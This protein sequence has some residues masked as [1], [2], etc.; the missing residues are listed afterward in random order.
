LRRSLARSS[1]KDS[2]VRKPF[3]FLARTHQMLGDSQGALAVCAKGLELDPQAAELWFRKGM[4][5]RHRGESS[6]AEKCWRLILTLKRPDQF[7]SVDQGI[8]GH[9]TRRNLAHVWGGPT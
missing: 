8:Y 7:S 3:T 9:I 1:P 2:I 5:H 6:E 4:L